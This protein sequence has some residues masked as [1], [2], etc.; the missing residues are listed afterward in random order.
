MAGTYRHELGELEKGLAELELRDMHPLKVYRPTV[1]QQPIHESKAEE[2]LVAGG[3]RSGKT[4]S[5]VCEV[6]SRI[7]GIPITGHDGKQIKLRF[8]RPTKRNRL[9]FWVIGLNIDHIG[10][11]IYHRLFSPGLGCE[12]KIIKD[13]ATGKWR[14]LN[15]ALPEDQE[16]ES[17]A[18]LSPPMIGDNMIVEGS[19]HMESAAGH[20]FKSVQLTNGATIC[21]YPS[22]GDR[23][24]MGDAVHGIW[25]DEDIAVPH[26]IKEWQDRLITTNGWMI[27]SVWPQA[28][29]F[30]LIDAMNRAEEKKDEE[31]PPIQCFMLE[32]SKNPYNS[33]KGVQRGLDRMTDE[34]D[35]AHRDRGDIRGLMGG[36]SMY[37]YAPAMHVVKAREVEGKP[38]HAHELVCSLLKRYAS[39]PKEW[40]RYLCID[41]SH[42]R[43]A[44][45]FGVVPPPEWEGIDMG[46]RLIIE[47]ELIVKRHTPEM[48]ADAIAP[49]MSGVHFE[50]F[51]MDMRAGRQT[52]IGNDQ[53]VFW[54]YDQKFRVRGLLSRT[55]NS[56]FV[57]GCDDKAKRR[58]TVREMM[59]PIEDGWPR[60]WLVE[61]TTYGTQGE[62]NTYT[63]KVL[64]V[65]GEKVI[66]DDALNERS[67]D[68]MQS[69]EYLCE[70]V[71]GR[72]KD[73]T[74]YVQPN[75]GSS[76]GSAA[77]QSAMAMIE[78]M[79]KT[80]GY[81]NLGPGAAA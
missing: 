78:K 29:N 63:K 41:P 52:T 69:L 16:R 3:K 42:T 7:L 32:G 51:I 31:E 79:N 71:S 10:Q 27:W 18:M 46:N 19:W 64:M 61:H 14:A 70:Y 17:E 39:L 59:E 53:S 47:R 49:L 67:K 4:L 72:F 5:A 20:I 6:G 37:S 43:T 26:F 25:I 75:L 68:A 60:L 22:T 74:A 9:L 55:T 80:S 36:M 45:L 38:Q 66:T 11:T 30:A 1:Y 35:L 54:S 62:F 81:V 8:H 24:K 57:G 40:T 44:C 65:N 73:G 21:A 23:P 76:R 48:L 50:A 12:F 2:L 33:A 34:E 58:R 56:G 77:Y 13:K 15:E 28:T